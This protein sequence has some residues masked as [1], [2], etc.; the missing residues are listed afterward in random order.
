MNYDNESDH[1]SDDSSSACLNLEDVFARSSPVDHQSPLSQTQTPT[2]S[3]AKS[4][5]SH[6]KRRDVWYPTNDDNCQVW[7]PDE[8]IQ[9]TMPG[10][11]HQTQQANAFDSARTTQ[12]PGTEGS[13]ALR[14]GRYGSRGVDRHPN[15]MVSPV[16]LFQ[17]RRP[18]RLSTRKSGD[19]EALLSYGD[20]IT[21]KEPDTTRFLFQN[22]KG[23]TYTSTCDDYRYFLSAMQSYSVDVYGMAETNTGWQ[24]SHLQS[25][26]RGCV[27]RQFQYGKTVFGLTSKVIDPLPEKET[28]QAGGFVQVVRGN[29]TTTV[30]GNSITDT[31][32]LGRWCGFTFQGKGGYRFSVITG[33]RVCK[34]LIQSAPLGRSFHR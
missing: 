28:F 27:K 13:E 17:S 9:K 14:Q 23:L 5:R 22:V 1:M 4:L 3:N 12:H 20:A 7:V 32:G 26:F 21:Y 33:Y 24:H 10:E 31:S 25:D 2:M 18:G 19:S 11:I 34:G 6:D 16:L 8:T 30:S 29:L 15:I